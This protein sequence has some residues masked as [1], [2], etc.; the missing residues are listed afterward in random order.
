MEM[1]STFTTTAYL[2]W[3]TCR[4]RKGLEKS[5]T[6]YSAASWGGTSPRGPPRAGGCSIATLSGEDDVAGAG[7]PR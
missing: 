7:A 4:A 3:P 6:F 1:E 5:R 2:P